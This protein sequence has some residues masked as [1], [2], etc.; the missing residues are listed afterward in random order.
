MKLISALALFLVLAVVPSA[1]AQQ[2]PQSKPLVLTN[3]TVI[4]ATGAPAQPDMTVMIIK[5]RITTLGKTGAVERPQD[6]QVIDASGKFLI[7]GLW[8]MH[9]HIAL[10][11]LFPGGREICLPL[12]IANGITGVRDMGGDLEALTQWREEIARGAIIGPRIMASGLMLDGPKPAFPSSVGVGSAAEARRVLQ[13]LKQQGAHFIKVQ[14]LVPREAYFAVVDEAKK[15]GLSFAGHIPDQI[16]AAEASDAGQ[17]SMEHLFGLLQGSSTE[18]EALKKS[19]SLV[20]LFKRESAQRVLS[21]YS[22][23]KEKALLALLAKNG[24]WQ[25]PTLIW[26]RG[27]WFIDENTFPDDPRLKYIPAKWQERWRERKEGLL[28]G[29]SADDIATGKRFFHKQFELVGALRR[30]GGP[31]LA[32][33]DTPVPYVFPGFLCTGS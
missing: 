1:Q 11:N 18:E 24:T 7:P 13:E 29:R 3:A 30:A 17:R 22:A 31:F 27:L 23:E 21:T 12:L 28:E 9:T 2:G 20:D 15:Q 16:T 33:T 32:G 10:T 8:D 5:D 14:S 6:A 25:C 26:V 4:D 19:M